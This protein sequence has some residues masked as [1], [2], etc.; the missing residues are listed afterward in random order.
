[1]KRNSYPGFSEEHFVGDHESRGSHDG[2]V[3]F[4]HGKLSVGELQDVL[5]K[6]IKAVIIGRFD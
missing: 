1:M 3:I 2:G 6:E 5:R 4:H